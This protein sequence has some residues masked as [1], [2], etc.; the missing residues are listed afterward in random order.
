M[1][2][3]MILTRTL[4]MSSLLVFIG[5]GEHSDH[6]HSNHDHSNH[7]SAS[8]DQPPS[9][10]CFTTP[11]TVDGEIYSLTLDQGDPNPAIKGLNTWTFSLSAVE[12]SD[13]F[14]EVNS[15]ITEGMC[16]L[17]VV[18]WMPDHGHGSSESQSEWIESQQ[19]SVSGIDLIMPGFWEVRTKVT[20]GSVE[21]DLVFPLWLNG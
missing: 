18:P 13:S 8:C 10:Q 20:C 15:L 21:E 4:F 14:D 3:S 2:S 7:D 1:K 9:G 17:D 19:Y 16:V 12:G 11:W 5:C 6:D